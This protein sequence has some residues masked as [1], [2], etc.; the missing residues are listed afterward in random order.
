MD[1]FI[2]DF[3]VFFSPTVEEIDIAAD[4][5]KGGAQFMRR[6]AD[7]LLLLFVSVFDAVQRL[8]DGLG[9]IVN[10]DAVFRFFR[11]DDTL[12]QFMDFDAFQCFIDQ[13]QRSQ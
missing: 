1:A 12:A 8:V 10:F 7:E 13:L 3:R 5:R 9:Q 2:E 11:N 6:I 4:D